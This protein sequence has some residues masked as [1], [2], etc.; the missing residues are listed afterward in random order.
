M[1]RAANFTHDFQVLRIF[2]QIERAVVQRLQKFLRGLK[3]QVPQLRAALVRAMTHFAS[4][5]RTYAVPLLRYTIWNLSVSP[6]RLSA[7]PTN[8]WPPGFRHRQNFSTSLF[9]SAS[10]KYIMTLRQKMM[11]LCCGKY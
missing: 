10:S 6:R 8:K 7:W 9:C 1:D 4:P 3:E 5:T 2:L 11:S